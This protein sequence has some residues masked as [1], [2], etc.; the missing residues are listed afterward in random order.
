MQITIDSSELLEILLEAG[1]GQTDAK[2]LILDILMI[3]EKPK[4]PPAPPAPRREVIS[5]KQTTSTEHVR[6]KP[7]TQIPSQAK[8][9]EQEQV[10]QTDDY[11]IDHGDEQEQEER[12][13]VTRVNSKSMSRPN[14]SSFGG[15]SAGFKP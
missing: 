7:V 8:A 14:F 10:E 9:A 2:A 13:T 12:P 3:Q 1:I 6:L 15:D 5:T 11:S 4:A